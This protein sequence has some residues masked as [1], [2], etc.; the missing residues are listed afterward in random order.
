[1]Q[2]VNR[3]VEVVNILAAIR[4]QYQGIQGRMK[5]Y[6]SLRVHFIKEVALDGV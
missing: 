6:D 2:T 4:E 3:Y 1:M 5:I